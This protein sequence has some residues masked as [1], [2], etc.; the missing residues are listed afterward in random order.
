MVYRKLADEGDKPVDN[1]NIYNAQED[2]KLSPGLQPLTTWSALKICFILVRLC[3]GIP[4]IILLSYT[5]E[6]RM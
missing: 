2:N 1:S 6:N 4:E 5:K 3:N